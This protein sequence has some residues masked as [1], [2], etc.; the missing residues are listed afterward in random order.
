MIDSYIGVTSADFCLAD[1]AT[2]VMVHGA[3]GPKAL[4]LY[5][6]TG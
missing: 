4:Y 5:V 3:H 2:L 6:I 1:T